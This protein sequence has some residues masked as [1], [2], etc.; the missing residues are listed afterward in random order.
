LTSF[1][2]ESPVQRKFEY[3]RLGATPQHDRAA[4]NLARE[5]GPT[6]PLTRLVEINEISYCLPI[7]PVGYSSLIP[8][9]STMMLPVDPQFIDRISELKPI[10]PGTAF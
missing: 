9:I 4:E 6:I 7:T 2:G 8:D 10:S 1:I 5:G 3:D